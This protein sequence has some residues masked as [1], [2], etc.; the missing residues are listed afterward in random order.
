MIRAVCHF[1]APWP[2]PRTSRGPGGMDVGE[3]R[4]DRPIE[5]RLTFDHF[6]DEPD[7]LGPDGIEA[8]AA[9]KERPRVALADLGDDE[10]RDDRRQDAQARLG[11]AEPGAGLG[12]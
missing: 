3:R 1:D 9:G 8:S 6:M 11:E 7:P 2:S 12:D 10:G 4:I 5:G